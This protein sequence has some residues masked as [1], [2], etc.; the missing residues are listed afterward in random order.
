MQHIIF[1][2]LV[3]SLLAVPRAGWC[4][5]ADAVEATPAVDA[6]AYGEFVSRRPYQVGYE[7]RIF[8]FAG[9]DGEMVTRQL[10]LWY[11]TSDDEEDYLY[12]YQ[13]GRAA[14][15]G[16]VAEGRHPL[17]VFSHGFMGS[18]DQS[19][20]VMEACA[21]AG[22]I[23]AAVNHHD[24]LL[25]RRD[26]R[27]RPPRAFDDWNDT[28]YADRRHDVV[29]LLDTL[30]EWNG[31]AGHRFENRIDPSA[32]GAMGHSLGGYT[33]LGMAGAWPSWRE[34]RIK[35]AVLYSPLVRPFLDDGDPTDV[36]IPVMLQGGTL[37][38]GIS[39]H[40]L[41]FYREL[42]CPRHYLMLNGATHLVWTNFVSL[43]TSTIEC[44]EEDNPE[45]V[46]HYTIAFFDHFLLSQDR[47]EI[48]SADE[49]RLYDWAAHL[50][51]DAE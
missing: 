8:E 44:L 25:N 40:L 49:E 12:L 39:E 26:E 50:E 48:L 32:I 16:E 29:T 31:T 28:T 35:A 5:D 30:L 51:V 3:V 46:V 37:D 18:S 38:F 34:P 47:E 7:R 19:I 1:T 9:H 42:E 14:V 36:E 2:F 33:V 22:Y 17:I 11:P 10:D 41:S 15:N 13:W 20:Y 23:V 6:E 24:A 21:R 4:D 27:V 45:L 43:P